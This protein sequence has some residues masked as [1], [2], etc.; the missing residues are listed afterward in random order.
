[1]FSKILAG[2]LGVGVV[3]VGG[4][5]YTQYGM[6]NGSSCCHSRNNETAVVTTSCCETLSR[7]DAVHACCS[8]DEDLTV[9]TTVAEDS[10]EVLSITPRDVTK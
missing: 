2:A 6:S 4:V 3:A 9:S 5:L 1:M 8:H 7:A 10:R